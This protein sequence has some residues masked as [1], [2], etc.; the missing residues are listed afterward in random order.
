MR[1]KLLSKTL[2]TTDHNYNDSYLANSPRA[3]QTN[4]QHSRT[5]TKNL[6]PKS[7]HRNDQQNNSNHRN[8]SV[9]LGR[10]TEQIS[11]PHR[12]RAQPSL[13][14]RPQPLTTDPTAAI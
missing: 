14:P 11:P 9:S 8:T 13:H 7:S 5:R 3:N 4:F 12:H 2:F 6:S 1:I 10:Q